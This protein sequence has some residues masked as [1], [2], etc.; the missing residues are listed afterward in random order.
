MSNRILVVD[1]VP[2]NRIILRVKL[3]AAYYDVVQ[4]TSGQAALAL[5][6]KTRPDMI[7]ANAELPD[8]TGRDLCAA[9]RAR[10]DTAPGPSL[11]VVLIHDGSDPAARL[12]SLA[13]GAD[14]VLDR[15]I[16]DL[17]MLAR[18]RSLLRARDAEAELMLREDTRRALGL[19]ETGA[20][21]E[22]PARVRLVAVG[23]PAEAHRIQRGL[24]RSCRDHIEVMTADDALRDTGHAP[25]VVVI[26]ESPCPVWT[27][28]TP[29]PE[30]GSAP[31]L[32]LLPQLR[33]KRAT[34]HSALIYVAHPH[35]RRAAAA[36]LDMGASDLMTHGP[37]ADELQ[38]RLRKQIAR[39]RTTDR[40][41]A[42]MQDSLR[43]AVTDPLTGLYNRRYAL[44]H[45]VRFA[46]RAQATRR[47]YA[48][49]LADL[50]RFKA[51]ND[52]YGHAAGDAVLVTLA[53]R[54]RD[55]LRAADL[56]ARWGGEEFLVA[57]P[58]TD[59]TAAA[60]TA[61]RLCALMARAPVLLPSGQRLKV[62]L[63]IGVA[64][65]QPGGN[66]APADLVAS[67]DRALYAA[68]S[69]G[70]NTVVLADTVTA[71]PLRAT[72]PRRATKGT[73][74]DQGELPFGD[75]LPQRPEEEDIKTPDPRHGTSGG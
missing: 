72:A 22:H 4:A 14:D 48:I 37:L 74:P 19:E 11:P 8:M 32:D 68:K 71:L 16:D 50:D 15:P 53:Q 43:A 42:D 34:R 69:A 45:T 56:V 23:D 25:D 62:T 47:P 3:S 70:R 28:A 33:A 64:I 9:I 57:M 40:L 7:L 63:S 12:A 30:D 27:A 39:K 58:D 41:R 18:L 2:T 59:R 44:P 24:T 66:L 52:G 51:I 60:G 75:P 61:E 5:L 54:L 6:R 10:N 17:V 38:I 36:A 29:G 49:L 31:G 46:E 1:A 67:A 26:F 21:F 20:G 35:Q 13:A 55:N 65:G 73:D